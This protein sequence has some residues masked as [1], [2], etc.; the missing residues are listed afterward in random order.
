MLLFDKAPSSTIEEVW[1]GME[2]PSW[3]PSKQH[4]VDCGGGGEGDQTRIFKE[5]RIAAHDSAAKDTVDFFGVETRT[6]SHPLL[7]PLILKL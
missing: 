7:V 5:V 3:G 2:A 1:R 4:R 6:F